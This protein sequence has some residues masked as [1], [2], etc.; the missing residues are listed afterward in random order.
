MS[1]H[2][3]GLGDAERGAG[4]LNS[5]KWADH[6]TF[7]IPEAAEILRISKWAAYEAA[8]KKE[9]P[10]ID[11]G[12]RRLVPRRGLEKLLSADAADE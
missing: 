12:R 11:I 3:T 6:N 7:T 8:K 2:S 9:L 1:I 4:L 10:T 5:P